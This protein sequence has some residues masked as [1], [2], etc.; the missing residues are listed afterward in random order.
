MPVA[1][2]VVPHGPGGGGALVILLVE[3]NPDH[4]AL[5]ER[6]LEE[7][8]PS[9]RLLTVS[10]GEEA[11]GYLLRQGAWAD[12]ERS[13]RP[14][15]IL[16]DLR[17]PRLD[18]FAVLRAVKKTPALRSIPV[19]ILTTSEADPDIAK[20]YGL[21]AN[22]YLVKPVDFDRFVELMRDVERY[23]LGWNRTGAGQAVGPPES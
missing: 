13:P 1:Q 21:H 19:V 12:E 4:A 22:S 6:S 20:S 2:G 10:D 3:D 7:G 14:H 8:A 9:A 11:M 16:L 15:L 17:L 23:W 5:V 18:G